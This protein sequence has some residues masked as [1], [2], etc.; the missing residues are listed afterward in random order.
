[1][2]YEIHEIRILYELLCNFH[3]TFNDLSFYISKD[4]CH[5]FELPVYIGVP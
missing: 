2:K 5:P 3:F 1:M 4:L